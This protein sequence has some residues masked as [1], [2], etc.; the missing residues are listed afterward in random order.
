MFAY[1]SIDYIIENPT[2]EELSV[3]GNAAVKVYMFL[4]DKPAVDEIAN[5]IAKA[6]TLDKVS[7]EDLQSMTALELVK[8]LDL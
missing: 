1:D 6:Y 2:D 3:L 7:L 8:T 5:K 4:L